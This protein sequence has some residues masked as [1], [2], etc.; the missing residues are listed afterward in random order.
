MNRAPV[1]TTL[2]AESGTD[3]QSRLEIKI[4]LI[5]SF[6]SLLGILINLF[7]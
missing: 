1:T 7:E 6:F 2:P 4:G 5:L 3:S